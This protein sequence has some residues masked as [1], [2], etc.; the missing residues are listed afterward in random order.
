MITHSMLRSYRSNGGGYPPDMKANGWGS[1]LAGITA[2]P[3]LARGV[4]VVFVRVRVAPAQW[5]EG[6]QAGGY[7]DD[8]RVDLGEL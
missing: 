2:L 6:E 1:N 3:P 7:Q 4:G 5:H 8:D